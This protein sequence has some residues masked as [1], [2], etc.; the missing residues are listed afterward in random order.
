MNLQNI[1]RGAI[2]GVSPMLNV[3]I[4]RST[5]YTRS[6]DGLRTPSYT[7]F[8]PLQAQVQAMSSKDLAQ[9]SG[10]NQQGEMLSLY[11][12]GTLLGEVAADGAGGDVA[13]LP[14]GS[15]WLVV[16]V[17][18]NWAPIDGWSHCAIARQ[19]DTAVPIPLDTN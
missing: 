9:V 16:K 18:E 3:T 11:V 4:R 19:R 8:G 15:T 12:N 7:T 17:L 6:S 5:G 14:D 1:T 10:L 13:I 2:Q